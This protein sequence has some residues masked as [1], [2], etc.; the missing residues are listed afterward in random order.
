M[1]DRGE[2]ADEEP[3][4]EARDIERKRGEQQVN[5]RWTKSDEK[6]WIEYNTAV[7]G[8]MVGRSTRN[9][10]PTRGTD[11]GASQMDCMK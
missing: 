4:S 10:W 7:V 8:G 1:E 11:S 5:A 3:A 6:G 2:K 9:G